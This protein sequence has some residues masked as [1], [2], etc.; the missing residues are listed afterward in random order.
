MCKEVGTDLIAELALAETARNGEDFLLEQALIVLDWDDT[1]LPTTWLS[2]LG[3][4]KDED[5][6][7]SEE[8]QTQLTILADRAAETIEAAEEQGRVVIITNAQ[9]GWVQHSCLRFLPSLAP[10][11][12]RLPIISARTAFEPLGVNCPAEW[13][14]RA[15]E[16]EV[17]AF[18]KMFPDGTVVSLVSIG[19]SSHERHALLKAVQRMPHCRAKS[20]RFAER[21]SIEQ[22]IEEHD[23][24]AGA[25][26]DV[27]FHDGD[28]DMDIGMSVCGSASG[29]A[30]LHGDIDVYSQSDGHGHPMP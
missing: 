12:R 16:Q 21:P 15:F 24:M 1:V 17:E 13:K 7:P 3:L 2:R 4:L 9:E 6:I 19:D 23:L 14:R 28:L 26:E 11:L 10:L 18:L 30:V 8:Q 5:N 22:L 27:A 29:I 20:V 25:M